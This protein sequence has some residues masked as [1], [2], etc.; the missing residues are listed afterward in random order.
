MNGNRDL[1]LVALAT[2]ICVVGS[3]ITPLGA[4]RVIFAVPL[5]LFLPGYAITAA[6]FG[7]NLPR[8]AELL[9]LSIGISLAAL[10]LGS[11]LLNYTPDGI[12]GLPWALLLLLI[13][14]ACC[15]IA[16]R[17]R[18]R[19]D[20]AEPL[21]LPRFHLASAA[22]LVGAVVAVVAALILAQT[23]LHAEN[24][25]GYSQLWI[26]PPS[27]TAPAVR[28]GV[29]SEEQQ[30]SSFELV[31]KFGSLPQP[32]TRTIS[33]EPGRSQVLIFH[34]PRSDR[35]VPVVARLFRA[36]RPEAVYRSVDSWVPAETETP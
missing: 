34:P 19:V 16:A 28:I 20:A 30:V 36:A 21:R 26:A 3:V 29:T 4:V 18:P 12:R 14:F 23:T 8:Q 7:R 1:K 27:N 10:T 31:V 35:P 5:C 22:L 32:T 17:R 2:A 15:G 9:P 11:I 33:L 13:V 6:A 25:L 24:A